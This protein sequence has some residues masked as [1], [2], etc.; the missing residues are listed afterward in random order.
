MCKPSLLLPSTVTTTLFPQKK[1]VVVAGWV[2]SN[3]ARRLFDREIGN[4]I[5]L[6]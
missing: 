6:A 1:N 3:Q 5:A 2:D 4:Y